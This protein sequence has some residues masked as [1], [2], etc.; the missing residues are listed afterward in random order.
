MPRLRPV[1]GKP[2]LAR[3]RRLATDV[4]ALHG[5]TTVG[6]VTRV[7]AMEL[8]G[9]VAQAFAPAHAARRVPAVV[10]VAGRAEVRVLVRFARARAMVWHRVA[11]A[12]QHADT[13]TAAGQLLVLCAL[14]IRRLKIDLDHL[15]LVVLLDV[16]QDRRE[17]GRR[18]CSRRW[19]RR[20]PNQSAARTH[21]RVFSSS[22]RLR[23][24][25]LAGV[26]SRC[27]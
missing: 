18:Q 20:C 10:L 15:E 22:C 19:T 6:D 21:R 7:P 25:A 2:R 17:A 12:V 8:T 13:A 14:R 24:P 11:L 16:H 23:W 4:V 26:G 27:S 9:C 1:Q 3:V 5:D